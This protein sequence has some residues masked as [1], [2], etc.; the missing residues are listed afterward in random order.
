M[1]RVFFGCQHIQEAKSIF[2]KYVKVKEYKS[3]KVEEFLM[4]LNKTSWKW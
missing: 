3:G 2:P 1:P 4:K